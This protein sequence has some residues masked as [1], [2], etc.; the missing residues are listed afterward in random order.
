MKSVMDLKK[1]LNEHMDF[2]VIETSFDGGMGLF[3][4]GSLKGATVIWSYVGGWEHV[5][6]CPKNRTPYWDEMCMLKEMFWYEDET[7]IQY[8]PAKS[9]YVNNLKNC[10]HLW[11]PIEQFTGE[12]PVPPDIM[13]GI[14]E[15]GSLG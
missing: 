4:K 6:I 9:N 11:K 10:L 2:R 3:I 13:V 12:L 1:T 5:S 8:H 14:K 7:V 15:V